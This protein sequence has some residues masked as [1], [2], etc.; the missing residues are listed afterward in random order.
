M[1]CGASKEAPVV[2][3]PAAAKTAGK[4]H[5]TVA[6]ANNTAA[7]TELRKGSTGTMAASEDTRHETAAGETTQQQVPMTE[8]VKTVLGNHIVRYACLSRKGRDPEVLNKPNQDAYSHQAG[9]FNNDS[10]DAFFGVYD[11]HGPTG[12][13]CAQFVQRRLPVLVA[14]HLQE[15]PNFVLSVDQ[16]SFALREAHTTCNEELH[17]SNINDSNSGTTSITLYLQGDYNRITVSNVGDSRAVLGTSDGKKIQAVPLSKDQTPRR[18]DEAKRCEKQGARILSF[19][20]INPAQQDDDTDEEDPPRVWAQNGNYPGTAFTRSLGDNVAEKL[21][22]NAVPEILSLKIGG[23]EKVIV[24]ATDGIFDVMDNQKVVDTCVKYYK[25]PLEACRNVIECAHAEWLKNEDC[26]DEEFANY[27][28]MTIVCI[29]LGDDSDWK[30]DKTEAISTDAVSA[31]S[32]EGVPVLQKTH[33]KRVR[34]KTLRNLD[35]MMGS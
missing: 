25:D 11:G 14:E 31:D 9:E 15:Q 7:T 20:Q 18:A 19:G 6:A 33:S 16:I 24:L 35:E 28:D 1:G 8:S 12:E 21:G 27:D 10:A 13:L 3:S 26:V 22:V 30:T 23:S 34:Q 29:F 32:A 5:A 2:T 4:H 17:A